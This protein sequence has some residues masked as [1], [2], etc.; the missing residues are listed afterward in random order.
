[1]KFCLLNFFQIQNN[2]TRGNFSLSAANEK[3]L[4]LSALSKAPE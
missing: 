3:K 2:E 4:K 1:V